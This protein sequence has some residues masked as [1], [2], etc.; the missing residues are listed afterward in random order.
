M[1]WVGT[2]VAVALLCGALA[3]W[4]GRVVTPPER[5][6]DPV[7]HL[8]S[9]LIALPGAG[10]PS[11]PPPAPARAPSGLAVPGVRSLG[12]PAE[13]IAETVR[14]I[15]PQGRAGS[16]ALAWVEG[17]TRSALTVGREAGAAFGGA[18]AERMRRR[19]GRI[20]HDP[21]AIDLTPDPADLTGI[22]VAQDLMRHRARDPQ[23]FV[24]YLRRLR[25]MPPRR[26]AAVLG[27]DAGTLAADG[28]VEVAELVLKRLLL[29]GV[30]RPTGRERGSA[31]G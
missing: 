18:F 30:V 4:L 16:S 11:G 22:A 7:A 17:R 15:G 19:L 25:S 31:P 3:L 9:P 27:H 21:L 24:D 26:A 29:R 13:S 6:P 2:V 5:P 23:G 8:A 28:V 12:R 20:L 10:G 1:E 14:R